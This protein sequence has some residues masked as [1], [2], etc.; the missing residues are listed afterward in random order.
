[1]YSNTHSIWNLFYLWLLF[2]INNNLLY[3]LLFI[4]I[5]IFWNTNNR[6]SVL[7]KVSHCDFS[8]K[9]YCSIGG[10]KS[11][12][13]KFVDLK[14]K[15]IHYLYIIIHLKEVLTNN[16]DKLI[17]IYTCN[18]QLSDVIMRNSCMRNFT[19]ILLICD[20]NVGTLA[21]SINH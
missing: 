13:L 10:K 17:Y 6:N 9:I 21:S 1:M 8:L 19:G 3:R 5:P 16:M 11:L 15:G 18:M 14:V 7:P 4:V 20:F 2:C 12:E